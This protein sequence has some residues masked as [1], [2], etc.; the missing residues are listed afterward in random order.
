MV[1]MFSIKA[2]LRKNCV[3]H[4]NRCL[5]TKINSI[6]ITSGVEGIENMLSENGFPQGLFF[7]DGT[8]NTTAEDEG[9]LNVYYGDSVFLNFVVHGLLM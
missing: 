6:R 4:S 3:P 9:A 5:K 7:A 1:G 8:L 2:I